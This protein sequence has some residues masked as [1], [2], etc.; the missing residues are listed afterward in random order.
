MSNLSKYFIKFYHILYQFDKDFKAK[1]SPMEKIGLYKNTYYILLYSSK[2]F[3]DKDY[4]NSKIF[5]I[6]NNEKE[7]FTYPN[8]KILNEWNECFVEL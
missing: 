4:G 5:L 6:S 1:L 3:L 8:R 2:K 7:Y